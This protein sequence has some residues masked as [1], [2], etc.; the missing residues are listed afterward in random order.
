M[1]KV[2]T[3]G[4]FELLP[5]ITEGDFDA[6]VN[7]LDQRAFD[8]PGSILHMLKGDRGER[9]GHFALMVEFDSIEARNKLF[10][11][12]GGGASDQTLEAQIQSFFES[13]NALVSSKWTWTDFVEMN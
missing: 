6:F 13:M 12:E 7:R 2:F 4:N 8:R 1:G 10:P 9:K 11:V 5:G 3:I